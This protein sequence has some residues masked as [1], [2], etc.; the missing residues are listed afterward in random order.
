LILDIF[1]IQRQ[2]FLQQKRLEFYVIK[3]FAAYE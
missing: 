3:V 2:T 1:H